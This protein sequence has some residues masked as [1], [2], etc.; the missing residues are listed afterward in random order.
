MPN[1]PVLSPATTYDYL[2]R[3]LQLLEKPG[4]GIS[5]TSWIQMREAVN[6]QG[7]GVAPE[8]EQADAWCVIGVLKAVTQ[9]DANP[10]AAYRYAYSILNAANPALVAIGGSGLSGAAPSL[11]DHAYSF[12]Q[13]QALFENAKQFLLRHGA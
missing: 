7:Q 12:S 13:V 1:Q 4:L 10:D 5:G 11:N 6:K 3:A 9:Y 2:T 8:S